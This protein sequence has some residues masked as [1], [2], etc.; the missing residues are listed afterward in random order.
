MVSRDRDRGEIRDDSVG[1]N[2]TDACLEVA[3]TYRDGGG[4]RAPV[5]AALGG[6][7]ARALPPRGGVA[8]RSGRAFSSALG[9]DFGLRASLVFRR[10]SFSTNRSRHDSRKL[11]AATTFY[12]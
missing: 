4:N 2:E 11:Q 6:L 8:H 5:V 3:R 7:R 12:E 9:S 1:T 10:L